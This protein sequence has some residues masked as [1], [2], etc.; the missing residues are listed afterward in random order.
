M[1]LVPAPYSGS[2]LADA[3][4]VY[5]QLQP[6]RGG[7]IVIDHGT[8]LGYV[9]KV[10]GGWNVKGYPDSAMNRACRLLDESGK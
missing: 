2:M 9:R 7:W 10:K 3:G 1:P 5:F 6:Y 8:H 4:D